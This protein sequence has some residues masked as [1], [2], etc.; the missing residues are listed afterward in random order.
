MSST[1]YVQ[2]EM[3]LAGAT[4]ALN[5]G[6]RDY[7]I[8]VRAL[9]FSETAFQLEQAAFLVEKAAF[10]K[11]KAELAAEKRELSMARAALEKD[12]HRFRLTQIAQ[13]AKME[14]LVKENKELRSTIARPGQLEAL[15]EEKMEAMDLANLLLRLKEHQDAEIQTL[16]SEKMEAIRLMDLASDMLDNAK[17]Y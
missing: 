2:Y 15:F 10:E 17:T 13:E 16:M 4:H 8:R 12:E 11:E 6:L 7:H 14:T 1:Y 3:Q 9:E 5:Q